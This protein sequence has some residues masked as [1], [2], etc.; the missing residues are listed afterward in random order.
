[1]MGFGFNGLGFGGFGFALF[2]MLIQVAVMIAI[3]WLVVYLVRH[4][5]KHQVFGPRSDSAKEILAQ[6]FARGEISE[7]EY[8]RMRDLL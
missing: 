7:E 6:R 1:M 8:R 2:G 3:V 5:T 4:F